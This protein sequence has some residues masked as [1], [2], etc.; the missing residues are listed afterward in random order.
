MSRTRI[1]IIEDDEDLSALVGGWSREEPG[2]E[3][4]GVH[5]SAE[6]AIKLVPEQRSDVVMVDINLPD[7]DGIPDSRP[8]QP[9]PSAASTGQTH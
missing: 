8:Q 2:L 4:V 7:M 3:L 6:E 9:G 1:A 5:G